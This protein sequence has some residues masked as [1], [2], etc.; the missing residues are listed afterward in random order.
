M[1]F[2][3]QSNPKRMLDEML[4]VMLYGLQMVTHSANGSEF[5][6]HKKSGIL[7]TPLFVVS[8]MKNSFFDKRLFAFLFH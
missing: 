7:R 6:W 5:C 4:H 2:V 3:V 1:D 8:Y